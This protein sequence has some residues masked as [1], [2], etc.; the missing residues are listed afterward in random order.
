MAYLSF[1]FCFSFIPSIHHGKA[2]GAIL[3]FVRAIDLEVKRQGL[4]VA[5]A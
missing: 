2:I 1:F 3:F 5:A 4:Y